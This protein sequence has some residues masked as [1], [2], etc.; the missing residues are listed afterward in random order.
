MITKRDVKKSRKPK[1]IFQIAN[2]L[3]AVVA[4]SFIIS[5]SS[6]K[7][8]AVYSVVGIDSAG[9]YLYKST[10]D[11]NYYVYNPNLPDPDV[12]AG[13]AELSKFSALSQGTE[14][15]GPP[16]PPSSLLPAKVITTPVTPTVHSFYGDAQNVNG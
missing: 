8:S 15:L 9:N 2:L 1:A 3:I 6:V 13:P 10:T 11:S 4:F 7:V 12:I 5:F 14:V 16:S